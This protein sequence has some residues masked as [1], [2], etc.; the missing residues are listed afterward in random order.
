L[1]NEATRQA[2]GM[3]DDVT[4]RPL[5]EVVD[6]EILID[7]FQRA[8]VSGK[9]ARAEIPLLDDHTLNA[10]VTPIPEVGRVAV[11]QDITHLK[12]L[13]QMK[14]E[15]VSAVSHDLRSPL[16]SIKGFADLL[17][18]AG[19]LNEQQ[20][21][22][23]GKIRHGVGTIAELVTDLLD[24]G[25]IEAEV[26][27]DMEPCNLGVIVEKAM[28]GQQGHAELKQ[29][30]L[31]MQIAPDLPL[32]QGNPLRLGQVV[33]NLIGNAIKYTPERGHISLSVI[34]EGGQV[35]VTVEDDGIGIPQG[36]L[37][38]IFDKFYRV[39]SPETDDIVGSGLGLSIVKSIV[40]K[41]QGRV[42]VRSQIGVGSAFIFVLPAAA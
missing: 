10:H 15:F 38:H 42:W 29:Q 32:V 23:L 3:D 33:S 27:M 26:R 16:T 19:S 40:E 4:G 20:V 12:E 2:F 37:A 25:R 21:Y 35:V 30:T 34:V 14:S 7:V 28:V 24:L 17:P 22:F 6:D 18:A 8:K 41:H 9:P 13:D 1:A 11:M 5:T 36:D 39:K 31:E